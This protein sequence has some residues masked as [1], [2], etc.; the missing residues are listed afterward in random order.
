MAFQIGLLFLS[1]HKITLIYLLSFVLI[2]FITRCHALS[3]IVIFCY[4]LSL[5]AICCPF[6]YHTSLVVIRFTT[7]CHSFSLVVIGCSTC[8]HSLSLAV[9]QYHLMF[10]STVFFKRSLFH[11]FLLFTSFIIKTKNTP[12]N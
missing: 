5:V 4:S 6:L 7:R 10:Y 12:R 11:T 1:K 2:R 9:I 8:C 3:L